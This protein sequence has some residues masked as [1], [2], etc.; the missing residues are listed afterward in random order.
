M[1]LLGPRDLLRGAP[2]TPEAYRA[3]LAAK[4]R[5]V[6]R[7]VRIHAGTL[8]AYVNRGRWVADCL[9]CSNGILIHPEW[10]E[11]SCLGTGCFYVFT[12]IAVPTEWRR[13]EAVLLKRPMRYQHWLC[14]AQR[15]KWFGRGTTLPDETV[16]ELTAENEDK[17]RSGELVGVD[18]P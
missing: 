7:Q 10:P 15:T 2:A 9:N 11:A 12:S 18:T 4:A 6:G 1:D 3:L 8:Q 17:A 14:A 13:I 16:D 5:R